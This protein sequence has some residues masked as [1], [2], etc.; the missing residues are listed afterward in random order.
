MRTSIESLQTDWYGVTLGLKES[1]IDS[2]I[3]NLLLLRNKEAE[4]FHARSTFSG[5]GGIADIELYLISE[6]SDDNMV[7]DYSPPIL[8]TK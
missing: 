7:F 6:D 8:P 3:E 5:S 1:E 4:H 2:L